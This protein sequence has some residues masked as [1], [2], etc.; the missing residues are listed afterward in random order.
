[1]FNKVT[2]REGVCMYDLQT[3]KKMHGL[4]YWVTKEG[5]DLRPHR[6]PR[7]LVLVVPAGLAFFLK[8]VK[9]T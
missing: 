5:S 1:M 6:N 8:V 7:L 4:I 2:I 3:A 9:Y